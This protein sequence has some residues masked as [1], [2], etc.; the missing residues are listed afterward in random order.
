MLKKGLKN[1]QYKMAANNITNLHLNSSD[2]VVLKEETF[3]GQ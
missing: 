2:E 3:V 1:A